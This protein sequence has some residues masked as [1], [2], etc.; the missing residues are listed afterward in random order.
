MKE[1][2][3]DEFDF[4]GFDTK[5]KSKV[6]ASALQE[7]IDPLFGSLAQKMPGTWDLQTKEDI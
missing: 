7:Q 2:K 6:P 5:A 1:Y 4:P 3:E